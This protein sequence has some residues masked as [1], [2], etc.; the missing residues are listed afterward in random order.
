MDRSTARDDAWLAGRGRE[1]DPRVK[2][3]CRLLGFGLLCVFD[4]GRVEVFVEPTPWRPRHNAQRRSKTDHWLEVIFIKSGDLFAKVT[5]GSG[6]ERI[7]VITKTVG[8]KIDTRP[9]RRSAY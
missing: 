5:A 1:S 8:V 3:L 6:D 9:Q 4:S 7:A 2:R